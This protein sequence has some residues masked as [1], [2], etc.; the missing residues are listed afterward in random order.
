MLVKD[1]Y[2][3][4]L[5]MFDS[6]YDVFLK[7]LGHKRKVE[8][9]EV[10]EN[11]DM[12]DL[13]ICVA[14]KKAKYLE[15][16]IKQKIYNS[17]FYIIINK[18]KGNLGFGYFN[19]KIN[20]FEVMVI[21]VPIEHKDSVIVDIDSITVV[22]DYLY[23]N[24]LNNLDLEKFNQYTLFLKSEDGELNYR[25]QTFDKLKQY[26]KEEVVITIKLYNNVYLSPLVPFLSKVEFLIK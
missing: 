14:D 17:K 20:K 3:E 12:A 19:S 9:V 2:V 15:K 22:E 1:N 26:E 7:S 5:K 11:V 21:S 23:I 10:I 8:E 13:S 25:G 18:V 4:V 16:M 6:E 24:V